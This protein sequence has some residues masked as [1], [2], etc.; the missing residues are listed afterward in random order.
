[1][2]EAIESGAIGTGAGGPQRPRP[3]A[4]GTAGSTAGG[5]AEAVA[6][7]QSGADAG[8]RGHGAGPVGRLLTGIGDAGDDRCPEADREFR[9]VLLEE[10]ARRYLRTVRGHARASEV[11]RVWQIVLGRWEGHT[12]GPARTALAGAYA[13]VG[14]DLAPAVVSACTVLGR[15]PGRA[16]HAVVQAVVGL[17]ADFAEG[18]AACADAATRDHARGLVLL[19]ARGEAWRQAEHLWTVRGRPSEAEKERAALDW[20]AALVAEALL[21]GT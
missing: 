8:A 6:G 15:V 21:R 7:L 18:A 14:H 19:C 11:P 13:L 10:L 3:S 4:G 5:T 1:V 16:E 17:I 2:I 12:A 20:R 9:A